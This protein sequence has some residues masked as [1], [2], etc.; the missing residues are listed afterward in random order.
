MGGGM[1]LAS[2]RAESDSYQLLEQ[3]T[4]SASGCKYQYRIYQPTLPSTSTSVILGH[5]FLRDQDNMIGLSRAMANRGIRVVT[6]DFCNMR[7]WN[8]HH[9][10]NAQDMRDLSRKLNLADDIVYA[11]FSAGALAAVLAADNDTR[12]IVALDLVDQAKLGQQAISKLK[13]PLIGLSGPPSS[14]NA[15]SSGKALFSERTNAAFSHLDKVAEATHCDFESPTNWLCEVACGN[16]DDVTTAQSRRKS[17]I[18][19][20]VNSLLPYLSVLH[21]DN[22]PS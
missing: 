22:S 16:Q 4:T 20:T 7:P 21:S 13:T 18:E 11:G 10:R 9:R 17:I 6:L 2:P 3:S 14:C 5:G 1:S 15:Y 8:G 12:A 19:K